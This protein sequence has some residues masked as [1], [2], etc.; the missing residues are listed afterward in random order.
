MFECSQMSAPITGQRARSHDQERSQRHQH[1]RSIIVNA[2]AQV[3]ADIPPQ[4]SR[5]QPTARGP[6]KPPMR[7][8]RSE[9]SRVCEAAVGRGLRTPLT[10][11]GWP[12]HPWPRS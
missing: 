6:I 8:R 3:A 4:R 7:A 9:R 5:T 10:K 12:A 2:A 1:L 11:N